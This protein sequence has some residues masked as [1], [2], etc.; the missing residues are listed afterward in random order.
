MKE[1]AICCMA[2]AVATLGDVLGAD[3]A[4]VGRRR[5]GRERVCVLLLRGVHVCGWAWVS[6]VG[7]TGA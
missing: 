7:A 4:Q 3:V 6:L 2:A 5:G 1:C